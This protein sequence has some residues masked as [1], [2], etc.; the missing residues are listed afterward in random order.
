MLVGILVRKYHSLAA[1]GTNLSSTDIEY[2]A[3][4][5]QVGPGDIVLFGHQSIA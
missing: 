3:V 5:G 2:I 4:A 1:K